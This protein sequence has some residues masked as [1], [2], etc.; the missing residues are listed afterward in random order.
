MSFADDVPEQA[1]RQGSLKGVR[2][3]EFA[4][5]IAGPLAGTLMADMGAEVIHVES[6]RGGDSARR[7]GP[8]KDGEHLWWKVL[9]RNKRSV[10][11]ELNNP[12]AK[13]AM[14]RLI[15]WADVV[16]VSFRAETLTRFELDWQSV[17][18]INPSAVLLQISGFGETSSKR[19]APGFGK[20][21]EAMSGVVNLTGFPDGPPVHTGFSHGD[22]TTGL[23]G[24]FAVSAALVRRNE[25]PE[26]RGEW[27][28]L[29]LFETLYRLVEWQVIVHDQLGEVPQRSGNSLAVSPAAVINSYLSKDGDWVTVTSAT[30]RSVINTV[31][32]LG[33]DEDR[34]QTVEQQNQNSREIDLRLAEWI[35][36]RGTG[37][38]VQLLQEAQVV[39]SKVYSM[40]DIVSDQTYKERG[41]IIRVPDEDLGAVSMQGVVPKMRINPGSVWRTG[42]SL[43]QDNDLV[44]RDWLGMDIDELATDEGTDVV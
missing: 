7:M 38:A 28:D 25:D 44:F 31:R 11:L 20:V 17:S 36:S 21:G 8:T 22:A 10:T 37:V 6:P 43:G 12:E 19:D 13:P 24:A 9:G 2:V 16:I 32:L 34:F 15:E 5:V 26:R 29:A 23:M 35:G 33:L 3:V 40:E 39:A 4:Q 27:I 41:G 42:P 14:R 18:A 30:P 1:V